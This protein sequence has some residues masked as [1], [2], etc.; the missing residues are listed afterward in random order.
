MI[1]IYGTPVQND[2]IFRCFFHF[3]KILIFWVQRGVKLC[4]A[5]YLR[6]HISYDCHLWCKCEMI[7]SPGVFFNF[8]ILIFQIVRDLK[9]KKVAQNDKNLSVAR[10]FQ[11]AYVI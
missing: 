3:L 10:S 1:V 7:I 4:C 6:N 11:E 5:P 8:K 9:G 2:N